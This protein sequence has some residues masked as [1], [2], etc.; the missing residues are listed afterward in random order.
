M[1]LKLKS[2]FKTAR[3]TFEKMLFPLKD[4]KRNNLSFEIQPITNGDEILNE[5]LAYKVLD[6]LV[7]ERDTLELEGAF[8]F[9]EMVGQLTPMPLPERVPTR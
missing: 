5:D 6:E 3:D 9:L 8:D 1:M 4:N 7:V 2:F